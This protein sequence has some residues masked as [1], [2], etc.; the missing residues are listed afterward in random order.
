MSKSEDWTGNSKST[1]VT[2]GASNHVEHPRAYLDFYATSPTAI[3][4]FLE[5]HTI[6][7][8]PIW[9]CAAGENNL[10]KPLVDAGYQ[11]ITSDIVERRTKLD[12][13]EDFLNTRTLRAPIILTNPPYAYAK[14]FVLHAID[15]GADYIYMFLKTTFLEGQARYK[16]LFSIYPPKEVW[17]FSAR[18]QAALN[19]NEEEFKKSSAASYSWFIWEK[20]FRGNPTIHWI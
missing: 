18:E 10:V 4:R 14:E 3:T 9:E 1:F 5:K 11:C 15:L 13:V 17:V 16:D 2:L 12:Y 20:G 8:L 7:R 6:P 19:N